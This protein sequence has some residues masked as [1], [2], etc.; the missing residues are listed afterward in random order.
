MNKTHR[1]YLVTGMFGFSDLLGYDYFGHFKHEVAH[2]FR[3]RGLDVHV[4]VITTP[5]TSS[6][7][8][9][10]RSLAR[11]L[12]HICSD[13]DEPIHLVGH[14]IGGIDIRL[15]LSPNSDLG[16]HPQALGWRRHVRSAITMN[17][18]HYGTPLATYFTTVAGG[19]A[20][21]AISLLTVLGLSIG[22]PS[23]ALFSRVLSAFGNFDQL[24]G[25]DARVF[26]RVTESLLRYTDPKQQRAL[27]TYL[28]KLRDDQGALIQT[29]PE[30]MD[31]FNAT[32]TDDPRVRYGS[33]V[34]GSS[35]M[36]LSQLG[37]RL[38]SPYDALSASLYR[39]IFRI[40]SEPH[41]HY[42]YARLSE[43]ELTSL[44]RRLGAP[45]DERS[46][47]GVVPTLSMVYSDLVWAGAAD[48]LDVI[49]H[50]RDSV[51]PASHLD[52]MTSAAAFGRPEFSELGHALV[53]FQVR[54]AS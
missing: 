33:V 25:G 26:R 42:R 32:I 5:P 16:L 53:D 2:H 18:P 40:T 11:T 51:R 10:A 20:L 36:Q 34:T 7:R 41:E 28:N 35:P 22:E 21:Y 29:T 12:A 14:S 15:V 50:F 30:A 6:I 39:T 9:R 48:H 24:F 19:R 52:W 45:L 13:G 47:D 27:V 23:L 54:A 4:D 43:R 8:H 1:L 49:G 31:L 38:L 46:N 44:G 37:L 17:T 3:S